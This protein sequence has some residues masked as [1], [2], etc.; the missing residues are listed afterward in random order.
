MTGGQGKNRRLL[1]RVAG[2]IWRMFMGNRVLL[3]RVVADPMWHL[4]QGRRRIQGGE[5][6]VRFDNLDA[7]IALD[8]RSDL[9]A[10]AIADGTYEPE[11]LA[12]IPKL[13]G[14]GDAINVGANV[15]VVAIVMR[16]AMSPGGRLLCVEP[17]EECVARLSSNLARAGADQGAIVHR[18]F[19]TDKVDGSQEMWTVAGRPEYSSGGRLV[20]PSV[21]ATEH[22]A[23]VVPAV[24]LDDLITK[25]GIRPTCIVMDCEGGEYHALRGAR[26][27]L[28]T[29]QPTL[30]MEFDP[31]LLR[32]NGGTAGEFLSFLADLGYR[33]IT[34]TDTAAEAGAAFSGTMVAV[35]ASRT[36]AA[37]SVIRSVCS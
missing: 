37:I 7:D 30:I 25:E 34:L 11:L 36:A 31:L 8:A 16:R 35:P 21:V 29:R 23:T 28:A 13:L 19:A 5:I 24:R 20:H 14:D 2:R 10:R 12:A 18:A 1:D 4:E 26:E 6:I 15:G 32:A 3:P 27:T 17:I 22:L 9:A 33:C